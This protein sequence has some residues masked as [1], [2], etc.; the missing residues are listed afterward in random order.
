MQT[1]AQKPTSIRLWSV[2]MKLD[3]VNIGLL[4]NAKLEVAYNVLNIKA[5]NGRLPPRKKVENVKV[6]AEIWELFLDNLAKIDSHG[7]FTNIA[8]TPVVITAEA[9]WTGWVVWKPIKLGN[10]NGAN[11]VV[12]SIIIKANWSA[13]VLNTN[14]AIYVWDGINWENW[15]TYITPMTANALVIT[16]DYTY[17]PNTTKKAVWSDVTKLLSTYELKMINTN[18]NG[19]KLTVTI[20][21]G[22][23]TSAMSWSF[24]SDD[25][26]NEVMKM[27]FEWEAFPDAL[28]QLLVIEDEQAV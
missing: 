23:S 17:T 9:L 7:V 6:T 27:P 20:P 10:K 18:E 21:K 19:K 25:S 28:N 13:L 11:T 16:A 26:V 4:E 24:V 14:Y 12:S 3:W 1:S 8:S 15:C 22:Y 2:E 5:H